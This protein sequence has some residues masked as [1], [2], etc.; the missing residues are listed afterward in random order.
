MLTADGTFQLTAGASQTWTFASNGVPIEFQADQRPG[1][2]GHS[3]P[4]LTLTCD[5]TNAVSLRTFTATSAQLLNTVC[6]KGV[7]TA[8]LSAKG[9]HVVYVV[10]DGHSLSDSYWT[11]RHFSVTQRVTVCAGIVK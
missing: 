4:K 8:F 6:Q 7:V 3:A 2:P 5:A 10:R 1:H 9:G 11:T